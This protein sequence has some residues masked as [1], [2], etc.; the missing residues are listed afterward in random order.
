MYMF[1]ETW[2]ELAVNFEMV[3]EIMSGWNCQG[4]YKDQ[5]EKGDQDQSLVDY[6]L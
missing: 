4:R 1:R 6:D 2:V 3:I 5:E